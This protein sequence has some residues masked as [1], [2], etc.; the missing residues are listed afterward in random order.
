MKSLPI[1]DRLDRMVDEMLSLRQIWAG[2]VNLL[3]H[4]LFQLGSEGPPLADNDIL[5]IPPGC[6]AP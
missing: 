1:I 2:L 6:L 3:Y 5:S 4:V